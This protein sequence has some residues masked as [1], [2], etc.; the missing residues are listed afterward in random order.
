MKAA[1]C[2]Q[3]VGDTRPCAGGAA[4]PCTVR[5]AV[6]LPAGG[7]GAHPPPAA[8]QSQFGRRLQE[9]MSYPGH[10]GRDSGAKRG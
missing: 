1:S 5:P 6:V 7:V 2:S 3:R 8:L 9:A 10:T 4:E